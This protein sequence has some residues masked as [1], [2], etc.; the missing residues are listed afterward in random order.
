MS[1]RLNTQRQPTRLHV[2][3]NSRHYVRGY[4][5][6]PHDVW[7]D[8][9][10]GTGGTIVATTAFAGIPG[11]FSPTGCVPPANVTA[12]SAVVTASPT[13]AWTTGQYVQTATAGAAGRAY[14]N[15]TAWVGGGAAP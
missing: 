2:R 9:Y 6:N 11:D 12:M 5:Q 13:T 3:K 10:A 14:W 7:G 15:G 1:E 8:S 4:D